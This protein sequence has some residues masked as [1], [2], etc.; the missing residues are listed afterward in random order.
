MS[1]SSHICGLFLRKATAM[2]RTKRTANNH[3][4]QMLELCY[5]TFPKI[6]QQQTG[7]KPAN[8]HNY[9]SVNPLQ[10]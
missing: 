8:F 4:M 9:K 6:G 2:L 10:Q 1:S 7:T 5:N 3:I